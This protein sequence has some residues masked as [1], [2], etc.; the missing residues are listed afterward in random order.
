MTGNSYVQVYRAGFAR[1][2]GGTLAV[3][4]ALMVLLLAV[5]G[6]PGHVL[7]YA[8]GVALVGVVGYVAYWRPHVRVDDDGVEVVNPFR[9]VSV[10][11]SDLRLVD[12]RYGLRLHTDA[13]TFDA[14]ATPAPSG[15][16]RARH[17]T[18]DAATFVQQRWERAQAL[19]AGTVEGAAPGWRRDRVTTGATAG[20][21]AL[22]VLGPLLAMLG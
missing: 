2:L 11:W 4:A 16:G 21:A 17:Q 12:G 7:R 3:V 18:S 20:V 14:W 15:M 5:S 13:G 6:S 8:G 22:A 10:P 1:A 9:S 19:G